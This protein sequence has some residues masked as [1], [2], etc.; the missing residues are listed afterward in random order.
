MLI[1]KLNSKSQSLLI[2][3]LQIYSPKKTEKYLNVYLDLV[4]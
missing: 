1:A 2:N 3:S 4:C